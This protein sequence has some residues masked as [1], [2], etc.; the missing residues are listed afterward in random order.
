MVNLKA[1]P[2]GLFE[3][4]GNK[5]QSHSCRNNYGCI[6]LVTELAG[7][8][9]S[10][11][12]KLI[13]ASC[14]ALISCGGDSSTIPGTSDPTPDPDLVSPD[15]NNP[16][17]SGPELSDPVV[18]VQ[19]PDCPTGKTTGNAE[20]TLV[21]S[22][23]IELTFD[24]L[25]T[26]TVALDE[27]KTFKVPS[28]AEIILTSTRGD[29]DLYLYSSKDLADES[30]VCSANEPFREDNCTASVTDGELYA[31]VYGHEASSFTLSATTDCSVESVNQWVYR[32]MRDYYLY[33]DQV[34]TLNPANYSSSSD[35]VREL[36]NETVDPYSNIQN[37][38]RQQEFFEQGVSFGFG[39]NW[40]YDSDDNPRIT[41]SL[42]LSLIHI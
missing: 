25:L 41:Y 20:C 24:T 13:F 27:I 36:R 28:D 22:Q 1:I 17:P 5:D 15:I 38:A 37:A 29:A 10:I 2:G 30:L 40:D 12:R 6:R 16:D 32:N 7:H 8:P 4:F 14:L 19:T 18:D 33:A 34:P 9:T 11:F 26:D 42:D 39:Y 31:A 21:D 35:L 23:P 3:K